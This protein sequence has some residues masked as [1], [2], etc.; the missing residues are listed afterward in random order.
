SQRSERKPG[1]PGKE[2]HRRYY[3][4][5]RGAK[6]AK[7]QS[8]VKI[9]D[10]DIGANFGSVLST[11]RSGQPG[12]RDVSIFQAKYLTMIE[13][14]AGGG[15]QHEVQRCSQSQLEMNAPDNAQGSP[16]ET[17]IA[18]IMKLKMNFIFTIGIYSFK[19]RVAAR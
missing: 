15:N 10:Q 16:A 6:T 14:D 9:P 12:A 17:H 7:N 1:E 8:G 18:T 11:V 2:P 13:S 4:H 19:G 3:I 5:D